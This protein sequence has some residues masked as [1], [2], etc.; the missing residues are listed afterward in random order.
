MENTIIKTPCGEL[1]W[2]IPNQITKIVYLQF[3]NVSA[4]QE[5]MHLYKEYFLNGNEAGVSF[6]DI[7]RLT[8]SPSKEVRHYFTSD[9]VKAMV[10]AS[11]LFTQ[12]GLSKIVGNIFF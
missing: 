11:A 5:H 1:S 8:N 4:A 10:K 12:N 7:S 6:S 2:L 9:E 3:T